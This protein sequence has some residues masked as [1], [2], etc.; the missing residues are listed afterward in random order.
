MVASCTYALH[1]REWRRKMNINK[2]FRLS[3]HNDYSIVY[4]NWDIPGD[5]DANVAGIYSGDISYLDIILSHLLP[6]DNSILL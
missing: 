6:H 3:L 5:F 2:N 1:K 4:S